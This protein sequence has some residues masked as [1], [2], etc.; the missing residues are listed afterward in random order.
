MR[1]E[2][3]LSPNSKAERRSVM[4]ANTNNRQD[5][6]RRNVENK[7]MWPAML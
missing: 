2:P 1:T 7:A 3:L 6:N 5:K 4:H